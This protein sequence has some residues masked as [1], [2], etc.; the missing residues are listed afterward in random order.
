M[1]WYN[2]DYPPSYKNQP[3]QLR[4]KA[5]EIANELLL[6]GTAEG[7]A[8]A[9]GLKRAREFFAGQ[10]K[11]AGV[12]LRK[13]PIIR[14]ALPSDLA[15]LY[16][17]EQGIIATERPFDPTFREGNI[18]FYDLAEMIDDPDVA[19]L[20]AEMDGEVIGSGYARIE[21]ARKYLKHA[22]HAYLGFMWVET[23]YRGQGVIH[24]IIAG[25]AAW[26]RS[27]HINE[28]NLDTYFANERA[29]KA[30][31]KMGFTKHLINMR[32]GV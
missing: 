32:M 29:I 11:K 6:N 18:N 12:A 8:I 16:R 19:L 10:D 27:R 23:A 9:T 2:G 14:K 21:A 25:L 24:Q 17:F 26:A 1:P 20:V 30:Y 7:I 22:V 15:T 4:Q 13:S 28:L 5:V 31:E 3:L